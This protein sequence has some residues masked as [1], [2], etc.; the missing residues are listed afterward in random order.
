MRQ[1][2]ILNLRQLVNTAFADPLRR[3]QLSIGLLL[4]LNLSLYTLAGAVLIVG[5]C[6]VAARRGFAAPPEID[7]AA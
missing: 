7:V 5:G 1:Q 3:L 4:F 6:L 2:V